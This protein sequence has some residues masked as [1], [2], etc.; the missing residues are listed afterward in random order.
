MSNFPALSSQFAP[1]IMF[2]EMEFHLSFVCETF[3]YAYV[4]DDKIQLHHHHYRL[5]SS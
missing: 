3:E 4:T 5:V 1:Y 2:S